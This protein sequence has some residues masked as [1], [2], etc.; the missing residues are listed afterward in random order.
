M[1]ADIGLIA[2]C[3]QGDNR[4]FHQLFDIYR[5]RVYALCRH[6]AGNPQDAEDLAQETFV[7]AFRA[8][9]AFRAES[10]FGTW[11]Y[12]IA[13]NRCT[14]A[15]RRRRPSA[16]TTEDAGKVVLLDRNPDPEEQ[17][18]RTELV[19]RVAAAVARLPDSQRLIYVL[20]TQLEMP[21]AHIARVAGCSEEAV[22]VRMHRARCRVRDEVRAGLGYGQ[23][24]AGSESVAEAEGRRV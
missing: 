19:Q 14:G 8:I 23:S 5:D 7:A 20:G 6:M 21:Y 1:E 24:T 16:P 12:R 4:A 13:V 2:A 22:K 15:L 9:G 3:Q 18:A 10:S 11:L 17:L